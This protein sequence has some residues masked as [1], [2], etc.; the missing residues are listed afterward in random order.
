MKLQSQES[1]MRVYVLDSLIA[2]N[3]ST[4]T[5]QLIAEIAAEI[6]ERMIEIN[7]GSES[8]THTAEE[9]IYLL[10]NR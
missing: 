4:L 8:E 5:P 3:G 7:R 2:R 6:V 9:L 1:Q 10:K